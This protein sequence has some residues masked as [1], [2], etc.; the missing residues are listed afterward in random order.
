M[1]IF[2][3]NIR[4]PLWHDRFESL[5][6]KAGSTI[7][8]HKHWEFQFMKVSDLFR[9]AFQWIVNQ[10]HAGVRLELALLGYEFTAIFY[11]S[12]HWNYEKNDWENYEHTNSQTYY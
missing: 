1:I 9:I 7:W 10:D 12:R 8:K 11:D 5:W 6:V 3:I 2:N 4:N